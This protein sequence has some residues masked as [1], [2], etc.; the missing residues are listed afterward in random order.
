MVIQTADYPYSPGLGNDI[1]GAFNGRGWIYID[2]GWQKALP[3]QG[4]LMIRA[5]VKDEVNAPVITSPVN[6]TFTKESH[7]TVTGT[8]SANGTS[9]SL[10]NGSSLV[11]TGTVE[12]GQFSIPTTLNAGSNE[13]TVKAEVEGKETDSS[14]PVNVT[15][16][17]TAPVVN[18]ITPD[19]GYKTNKDVVTVNGLVRDDNLSSLM[20]ND[21]NVKINSDGSI[22]YRVIVDPGENTITIKARDLAGNETVVTRKVIVDPNLGGGGDNPIPPTNTAPTA[23]D[24]KVTGT[25]KAGSVLTGSYT[26]HDADNDQEGTSIIKWSRADDSKGTNKQVISGATS[27]SYTLTRDDQGKF[28]SMEVTPVAKTGETKGVAVSSEYVAINKNSAPKATK[29]T[30]TGNA[31]IGSSLTGAYTYQDADNDQE[32]TSIIKWFR[33]DDSKGKNKKVISGAISKSY[34]LTGADQGKFISMEVTPVA[35]T[36]E[37]KG[38]AVSSKYVAI[39]S[40]PAATNLKVLGTAKAGST[41]TA[42]YT[43]KDRE[44]DKEGNSI[45]QWYRAD[46]SKGKNKKAILG[47]KGTTYK[48]AK[49]DQGKFIYFTIMPVA[50]VGEKIGKVVSSSS[51]SV[52]KQ[53]NGHFTLDV[54]KSKRDIDKLVSIIKKDYADSNVVINKIG[55]YYKLSVNFVDKKRAEAVAKDLKRRKLINKYYLY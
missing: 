20:I 30:V 32:G 48:V 7:V 14:L 16:D 12:S 22:S 21:Q 3:Q 41:L 2:S 9:I 47:A 19:D 25:P 17:Q 34:T 1:D 37:T 10:F 24:V 52:T 27:P 26:Y 40:A 42:V 29:V 28:I 13:L 46:D 23:S 15:L 44:N 43:Y 45:I 5:L 11:G 53:Y 35:K 39:N 31:K 38:V 18:V 6:K 54:I 51:V 55:S 4:N 33:A 8:S 49:S 36:G 50:K